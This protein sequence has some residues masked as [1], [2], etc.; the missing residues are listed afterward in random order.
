MVLVEYP[1]REALMIGLAGRIAGALGEV[2]RG[3]GRA[4]IAVP[5]GTTPGPFFDF[6][7]AA[8][9]GW[10]RVDVLP[11]DERLVPGDDMRSNA[12]MIRARLLRGPAA[13][14]LFV[15]LGDAAAPDG[16]L[17]AA[18]AAVAPLL[19]LDLVVLG[20]G[21]DGHVASLFPGASELDD[22]LADDA[23]PVAKITPPDQPEARLSLT[24]PVLRDAGSV[25]VLITGKAKRAALERA[26]QAGSVAAAPVCAL[27]GV[28]QVH[29][30]E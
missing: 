28:A 24:L 3:G 7:S 15:A 1:D 13:A 21:E 12:R 2:L 26:A 6:L 8:E 27:L 20:M 30:A 14:A 10:D 16:G 19:P 23:P 29:Y 17:A 25:H 22:A 5:G 9:I 11:T 4:S 18:Q